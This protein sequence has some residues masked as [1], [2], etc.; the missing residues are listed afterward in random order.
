MVGCLTPTPHRAW[1]KKDT[2]THTPFP[3]GCK[4][5]GHLP[6]KLARPGTGLCPKG[7]RGQEQ[8]THEEPGSS[9]R[10]HVDLLPGFAF[11]LPSAILESLRAAESPPKLG[12]LQLEVWTG[13]W[14][15]SPSSRKPVPGRPVDAN[16]L[17]SRQEHAEGGEGLVQ[18]L[19]KSCRIFPSWS[20]GPP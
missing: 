15:P 2:H 8:T 11:F 4:S 13:S 12:S 17:E 19:V 3:T 5:L 1:D 20:R 16:G 7:C 10:C 9:Q 18:G 6:G 14:S